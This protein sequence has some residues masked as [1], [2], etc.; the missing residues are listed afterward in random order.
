ME[1][2]SNNNLNP[3]SNDVQDNIT[4]SNNTTNPLSQSLDAFSDKIATTT[5]TT[6]SS[7]TRTYLDVHTHPSLPRVDSTASFVAE[8]CHIEDVNA[9]CQL[10]SHPSDIALSRYTVVHGVLLREGQARPDTEEGRQQYREYS[11]DGKRG[12][13][14]LNNRLSFSRC[15]ERV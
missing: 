3:N 9:G 1:Q 7:N 4:S 12:R 2:P 11:N 8:A 14:F 5:T 6:T 13:F 15:G 10:H